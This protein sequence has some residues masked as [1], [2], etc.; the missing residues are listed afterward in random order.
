MK[1]FYRSL[2]TK[3]GDFMHSIKMMLGLGVI[4]SMLAMSACQKDDA[5]KLA[6]Q[7]QLALLS[8]TDFRQKISMK[9]P[10]STMKSGQ[11]V[12]APVTITN[13]GNENWPAGGGY[14]V[15]LAYHWY[16][17][18]GNLVVWDGER[19]VLPKDLGEGESVKVQA[20]IK[21]PDK[22]GEYVLRMTMVQEFVAWF[23][24]K[25]AKPLTQ[26]VTIK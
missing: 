12:T 7:K 2:M 18:S 16:D 4:A 24:D 9:T 22:A 8:L 19:T 20:T 21:A 25:G 15:H 10:I 1:N 3:E 26:L 11:V 13:S 14:P 23:E 6:S 17:R 5:A